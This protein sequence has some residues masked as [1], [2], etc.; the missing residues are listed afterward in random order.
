MLVGLYDHA[1]EVVVILT[2]RSAQLRS[3]TFEVS[4]P[5]GREDP[6]DDN[7]WQTALREAKEE[8]DLD[9]SLV[10]HLGELDR[11]VTVGSQSLIH[12]FV[13]RVEGRPTLAAQP[14]EVDEILEV[15]LS[16]LL[17]DEVWREEIWKIG[18]TERAITFFELHGNTVWG[19][20]A[21][22]LRQFLTLV[23]ST[24]DRTQERFG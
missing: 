24:Q 2:R 19:A 13:A 5:G 15:S 6:T 9:P 3:H 1:G 22:I 20:T 14:E 17:L 23:T 18:G 7:L 12:P 11:F 8:V 10:H 16:E 4:F 21:S